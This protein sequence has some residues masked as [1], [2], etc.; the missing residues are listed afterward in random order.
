MVYQY[1]NSNGNIVIMEQLFDGDDQLFKDIVK[2]A[3]IYGEYGCGE[4]TKWVLKNTSAQIFSV[5]SSKEWVQLVIDQTKNSELKRV[6]IDYIDVGPVK[7]WGY[8]KSYQKRSQFKHYVES[9]WGH[10]QKPDVVLVD[11][12]FRVCSFLTTLKFANPGTLII[13][14]DYTKRKRYHL[15]EEYVEKKDT[16]GQQ[17]IFEVP[18]KDSIDL[19]RLELDIAQFQ[20]V[21]N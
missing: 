19:K 7:K 16:Y 18:N 12:R 2:K 17:A 13:F 1:V 6:S 14:D 11:G 20:F 21:L 15:V 5:D 3:R 8:P 4:S 10:D 9:I